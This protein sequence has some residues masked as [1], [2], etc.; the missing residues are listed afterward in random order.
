MKQ[1]LRHWVSAF[2]FRGFATNPFAGGWS[3]KSIGADA[4]LTTVRSLTCS[5]LTDCPPWRVEG[6]GLRASSDA[7]SEDGGDSDS[8]TGTATIT[9]PK[10]QTKTPSLYRVILMNDDFTP[11]DFVIHVIQKFFNK[12]FE[13]ATKIML[14]VHYQGAGICGTFSYDIAETKV[15]QVNQY[16][17]QNKHPLKCTME[18]A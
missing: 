5:I 7:N 10:S 12:D 9:K 11:M 2:R 8:G 4:M 6:P 16:S 14:E 1:P 17:R 15:Y 3:L 13:E 18:K